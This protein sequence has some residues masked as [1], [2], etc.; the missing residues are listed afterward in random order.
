MIYKE[1]SGTLSLYSLIHTSKPCGPVFI[2][3]QELPSV[4]YVYT[5]IDHLFRFCWDI[6]QMSLEEYVVS[7]DVKMSG[8]V[9]SNLDLVLQIYK[10]E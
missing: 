7:Q 4:V 10:C 5:Q 6:T 3:L 1:S 8:F 9:V 2:C